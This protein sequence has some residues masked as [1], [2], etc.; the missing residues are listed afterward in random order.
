MRPIRKPDIIR[1]RS[2]LKLIAVL[3]SEGGVCQLS[4]VQEPL[5]L[6]KETVVDDL[7]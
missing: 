1:N 6:L 7:E 5:N 4:K 3:E 2:L